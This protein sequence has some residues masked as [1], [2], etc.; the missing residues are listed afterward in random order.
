[1]I[2]SF[3][4]IEKHSTSEI[5][6]NKSTFIAQAFP[7]FSQKETAGLIKKVKKQYYDASHHPFAY[8]SGIDGTN[9]RFSDDGEPS[10]S[11]GKPILEAIDKNDLTN[12]L[13]IVTR[14][15]GGIKLGVGGL[16]R[17]Y[18]KSADVCLRSASIVQKFITEEMN[19]EFDYKYVNVIMNLMQAEKIKIVENNSGEKYRLTLEVRLSKIEKLKQELIS[20]TSG[21]VII[22]HPI[23]LIVALIKQT[24]KVL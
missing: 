19:L 2:D 8:R 6:V 4:T 3:F 11:S 12:V 9:F 22:N 17:V 5:K 1:M 20:L 16:M 21:K 15:F 24:A 10:G 14:Y 7:I 13:V 23:P 18:F